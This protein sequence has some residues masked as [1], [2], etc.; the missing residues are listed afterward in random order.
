M[1]Y[2]IGEQ[3]WVNSKNTTEIINEVEQIA[4][5]NVYYTFDGNSYGEKDIVKYGYYYKLMNKFHN[6]MR[7]VQVEVVPDSLSYDAL[8]KYYD[9]LK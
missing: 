2:Q 5:H 8:K 1:K 3:V 4:G 6:R 7:T 9:K